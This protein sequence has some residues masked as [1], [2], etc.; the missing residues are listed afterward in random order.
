MTILLVWSSKGIQKVIL[1][2]F[3]AHQYFM[4]RFTFTMKKLCYYQL[5]HNFNYLRLYQ[6]IHRVDNN[7][8]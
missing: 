1:Q 7:I 8:E 4:F 5:S 2:T 3:F 6:R